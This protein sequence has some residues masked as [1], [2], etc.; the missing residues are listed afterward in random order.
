VVWD[1]AGVLPAAPA[2]RLDAEALERLWLALASPD[3]AEALK[4]VRRLASARG[5]ALPLLRERLGREPGADPAKLARLLADLNAPAFKTR[6]A[7][8]AELARLGRLAE[9]ALRRALE[10]EPAGEV[11]R[12]VEALLKKLDG[13]ALPAGLP[14]LRVVEVLELIGTPEARAVIEAVAQRTPIPAVGEE[15]RA[16]LDRL[17]QH[18]G[19]R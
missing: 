13:P 2:G 14:T 5:Q 10:G 8:S 7:A 9:P 18:K 6:E 17:G 1:V 3:G 12:R 19:K 15:A 11:R 4:A 16:A